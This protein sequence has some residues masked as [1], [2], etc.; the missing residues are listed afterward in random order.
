MNLLEKYPK[1]RE[2]LYDVQWVVN[3]LL[4]IAGVVLTILGQSPLWYVIVVAVFNFVWSYTGTVARANVSDPLLVE[5]PLETDDGPA[6]DAVGDV[7]DELD[8]IDDP[9]PELEYEE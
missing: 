8:D 3:L 4:G 1:V 6:W 2:A 5:A 9:Q 7:E